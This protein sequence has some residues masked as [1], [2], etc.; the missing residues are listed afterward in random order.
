MRIVDFGSAFVV[1]ADGI[2]EPTQDSGTIAYRCFLVNISSWQCIATV[3]DIDVC[4]TIPPCCV[5]TNRSKHVN[6]KWNRSFLDQCFH[7]FL[8]RFRSRWLFR[9]FVFKM[10]VLLLSPGLLPH[11]CRSAPEV[12]KGEPVG[13]AADMWSLGVVLYILLSGVHPF[14]LEGGASDAVVR[15]RVLKGKVSFDSRAWASSE[16]KHLAI[17]SWSLQTLHFFSLDNIFFLFSL[18]FSGWGK[19]NLLLVF[20]SVLYDGFFFPEFLASLC[21]FSAADTFSALGSVPHDGFRRF[22]SR[23][24]AF[25]KECG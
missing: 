5:H 3:L 10:N 7:S 14:D 8:A 1:G 15:D 19:V 6:Q 2:G 4:I 20:A 18:S 24:L 9:V 17:V 21:L 11:A 16:G 13:T 25:L 23:M 22:S 12:L